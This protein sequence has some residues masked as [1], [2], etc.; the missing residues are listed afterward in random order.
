MAWSAVGA[1]PELWPR[2]GKGFLGSLVLLPF[3]IASLGLLERLVDKA[4]GRAHWIARKCIVAVL[5]ACAIESVLALAVTLINQ[6]AGSGL[7][8]AWW[9]AFSRA[10]PAGLALG[11]FMCFYMKPKFDRMRMAALA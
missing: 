5:T 4:M 10:L 8:G 6:G 11:F 9:M 2:W 7:A 1:G 3:I